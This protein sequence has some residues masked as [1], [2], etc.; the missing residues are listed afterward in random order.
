VVTPAPTPRPDREA[1]GSADL[2]SFLIL[3]KF[4]SSNDQPISHLCTEA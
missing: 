4:Y 2:G 1:G 3:P